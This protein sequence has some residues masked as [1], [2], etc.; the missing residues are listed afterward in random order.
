MLLNL[1]ISILNRLLERVKLTFDFVQEFHVFLNRVCHFFCLLELFQVGQFVLSPH[2]LM[3]MLDLDLLHVPVFALTS[4][5][6]LDLLLSLVKLGQGSL[7]IF[8]SFS[9]FHFVG[10]RI[11]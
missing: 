9:L 1:E 5:F 10:G 7:F 11:N 6:L 4:H 2:T 8:F 3:Q